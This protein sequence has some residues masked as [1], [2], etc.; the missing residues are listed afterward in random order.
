[1]SSHVVTCRHHW[2]R[3]ALGQDT[4]FIAAPFIA[5]H[6]LSA[7]IPVRAASIA[8]NFQRLSQWHWD[9]I[10]PYHIFSH[11]F[12]HTLYFTLDIVVI[13]TNIIYIYNHI[14]IHIIFIYLYHP[15]SVNP[16]YHPGY[17]ARCCWERFLPVPKLQMEDLGRFP[18]AAQRSAA[19]TEFQL[20]WYACC[21]GGKPSCQ[22]LRADIITEICWD[23]LIRVLVVKKGGKMWCLAS[24][25]C[26]S[27]QDGSGD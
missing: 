23:Q 18:S 20:Q 2:H 22:H 27:S 19:F 8:L 6:R 17:W 15:S 14:Y 26:R 21:W 24:E 4:G 10:N 1:M 25:F 3:L 7:A 16:V 12:L 5:A 13:Y 9:N 11:V